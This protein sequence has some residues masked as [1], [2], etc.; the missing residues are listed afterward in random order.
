VQ[1]LSLVPDYNLSV[2]RVILMITVLIILLYAVWGM[3][4]SLRRRYM[5]NPN[6]NVSPDVKRNTGIEYAPA[7]SG[8]G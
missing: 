1:F 7:E 6:K 5:L 2:Y 8:Y 4:D 3:V